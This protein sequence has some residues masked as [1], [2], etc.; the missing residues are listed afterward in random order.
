MR[1]VQKIIPLLV[2][3]QGM[4]FA[5]DH[6]GLHYIGKDVVIIVTCL[7]LPRKILKSTFTD[8]LFLGEA[9]R[10]IEYVLLVGW[11]GHRG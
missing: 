3:L 4:D 11:F 5:I 1:S 2:I 9:S 10:G 7:L 6:I 8:R